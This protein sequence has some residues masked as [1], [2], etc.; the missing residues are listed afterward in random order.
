M[1][2]D[3]ADSRSVHWPPLAVW[4]YPRFERDRLVALCTTGGWV[5]ELGIVEDSWPSDQEVILHTPLRSMDGITTLR[6]GS[7][8]VDPRT[9]ED[10]TGAKL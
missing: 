3:R 9:Y 2:F 7:V 8:Y 4:P 1:A 5:R 6:I 10:R